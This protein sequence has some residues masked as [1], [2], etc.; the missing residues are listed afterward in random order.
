MK[1]FQ[2]PSNVVKKGV[3]LLLF[4]PLAWKLEFTEKLF[5]EEGG[6]SCCVAWKHKG[7]LEGKMPL[8]F[9]RIARLRR[10]ICISFSAVVLL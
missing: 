7:M 4:N 9:S 6:L 3:S 2:T 1:N 8:H 5:T 10:N